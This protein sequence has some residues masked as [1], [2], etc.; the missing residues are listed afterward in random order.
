MHMSTFNI[1]T[2]LTEKQIQAGQNEQ[3]HTSILLYCNEPPARMCS[4]FA[5]MTLFAKVCPCQSHILSRSFRLKRSTLLSFLRSSA[6]SKSAMVC[7]QA[8]ESAYS[9]STP[10]E[11]V[12]LSIPRSLNL[13]AQKRS[14]SRCFI[15]WNAI[16]ISTRSP[17]LPSLSASV[18]NI[19][20]P[21]RG[22]TMR[23]NCA[24]VVGTS[25][26]KL[27]STRSRSEESISFCDSWKYRPDRRL[28]WM[29]SGMMK[30]IKTTCFELG[31]S[32]GM[33]RT[34]SKSCTNHFKLCFS[35]S[36][37]DYGIHKSSRTRFAS[38]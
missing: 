12:E 30:F 36:V 18:R 17:G 24:K 38:G 4:T 13:L 19:L 20:S 25:T 33:D 26:Y 3:Y 31:G 35:G 2:M 22:S 11:H 6:M 9:G 23:S 10:Q 27:L 37:G 5:L 32:A 29:W 16:S 34:M 21:L 7:K 8:P 14:K 1:L 15:N 28:Y